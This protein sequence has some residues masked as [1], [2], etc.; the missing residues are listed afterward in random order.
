MPDIRRRVWDR[1]QAAAGPWRGWAVCPVLCIAELERPAAPAPRRPHVAPALYTGLRAALGGGGGTAV[2]LDLDPLVGV[3]LAARLNGERIAHAVLVLPRW[4]YAEAV[5]PFGRL[6]V[7]LTA[8]ARLLGR[9]MDRL[10]N[11]VFVLDGQRNLPLP[12][13]SAADRRADNRF[14][15]SSADLPTLADLRAGEISRVVKVARG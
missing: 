13:R 2:V 8:G 7:N 10:P 4:P 11:V 14:R 6:L 3:E 15:L 5:L 12:G 9:P 1:W